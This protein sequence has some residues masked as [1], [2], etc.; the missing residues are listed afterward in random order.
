M[1]TKTHKIT[2]ISLDM[3][4]KYKPKVSIKYVVAAGLLRFDS[5]TLKQQ[6]CTKITRQEYQHSAILQNPKG[7]LAFH[8]IH[9]WQLCRALFSGKVVVRENIT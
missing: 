9:T 8:D 6:K 5:G 1:C 4:Q 2:E 3:P 7:T